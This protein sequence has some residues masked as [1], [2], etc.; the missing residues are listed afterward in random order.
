VR[1]ERNIAELIDKSALLARGQSDGTLDFVIVSD[2][3]DQES[4]QQA[5]R[6][7]TTVIH[8]ASPLAVEVSEE[9]DFVLRDVKADAK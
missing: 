6:D 1:R 4:L 3:L 2:F 7:V 8:L 5:L 9:G